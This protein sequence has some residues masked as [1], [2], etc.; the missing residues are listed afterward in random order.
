MLEQLAKAAAV[1]MVATL[2]LLMLAAGVA[3]ADTLLVASIDSD[4]QSVESRPK[5]GMSMRRLNA[6]QIPATA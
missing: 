6:P 1:V 5:P 4:K 3:R 2:A